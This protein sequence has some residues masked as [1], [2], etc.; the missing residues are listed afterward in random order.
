M[1]LINNIEL[2]NEKKGRCFMKFKKIIC[3]V[4]TGIMLFGAAYVPSY[5]YNNEYCDPFI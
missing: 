2:N 1:N 4:I 3:A 5:A